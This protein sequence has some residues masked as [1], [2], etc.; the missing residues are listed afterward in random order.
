MVI[1]PNFLNFTAKKNVVKDTFILLAVVRK[2]DLLNFDL[3]SLS[4]IY[5]SFSNGHLHTDNK[6]V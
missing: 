3:H 1:Y 5:P 4:L 6:L 2:Q